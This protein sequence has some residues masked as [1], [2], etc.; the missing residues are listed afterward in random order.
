GGG[1]RS[2]DGT[3]VIED[4][5]IS[6]NS[7]AYGGGVFGQEVSLLGTTVSDNSALLGGGGVG[8]ATLSLSNSSI[9]GN[10]SEGVGGGV[11]IFDDYYTSLVN[12]STITAN[13]AFEGGGI[14]TEFDFTLNS[15]IVYGNI[16]TGPG[17]VG[18]DIHPMDPLAA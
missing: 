17:G 5:T 13:S 16:Q 1:V 18:A 12:N 10:S 6:G 15:S 11:F 4:S 2:F 14:A 9:S 8:A 3:I 7:A